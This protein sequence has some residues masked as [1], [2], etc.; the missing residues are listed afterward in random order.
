MYRACFF[1]SY[2]NAPPQRS[3]RVRG[4]TSN[5]T[6]KAVPSPPRFSSLR[7][8]PLTQ[9]ANTI[10]REKRLNSSASTAP[11]NKRRTKVPG[12][13]PLSTA[14]S[15]SIG[16]VAAPRGGLLIPLREDRVFGSHRC[17]R[18]SVLLLLLRSF[19]V[20]DLTARPNGR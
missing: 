13:F 2:K 12:M 8:V 9:G 16:D 3:R 18:T 5:P 1:F 6:C 19:S 4:G 14:S 20:E 17:F 10:P 7:S 11:V 15:A